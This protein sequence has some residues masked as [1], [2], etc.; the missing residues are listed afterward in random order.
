[1]AAIPNR[2]IEINTRSFAEHLTRFLIYCEPV[3]EKASRM[4]KVKMNS[5]G[6]GREL[7]G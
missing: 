3:L 4:K 5:K 2:L 7:R 1:M 6:L